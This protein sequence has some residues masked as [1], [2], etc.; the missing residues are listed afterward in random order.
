MRMA[1][2]S[3]QEFERQSFDEANARF[4]QELIY[5]GENLHPL[6][7]GVLQFAPS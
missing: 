6:Q 2:F 4:N 3:T 1:V 5:F 7:P